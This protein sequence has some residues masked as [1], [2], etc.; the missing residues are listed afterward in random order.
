MFE[1]LKKAFSSVT[2]NISQ[3]EITSRDL[4]NSLSQIELD[5]L[6]CDIAQ[7]ALDDIFQK[8]KQELLGYKLEKSQNLEDLIRSRLQGNISQMFVTCK[9]IDLIQEIRNKSESKSGPF[10]IVFVGI[11]GSGKTTTVAKIGNRLRRNG[12]SVVM[13]AADTHRSGAIE[14]LCAHGERL[15]LKVIAQR[16]G[17]DPSAVGRDAVEFAKKHFIDVVLIDTAGRMQT[18]KNLMDEINKVVRVVKPDIKLFVGDSLAGNDTINQA[19]EFYQYTNFDAAI[20]TKADADS[21]GGSAISIVS[22]TSKPI[23]YFGIGQGYDDLL[24]FHYNRF[25]KSIFEGYPLIAEQTSTDEEHPKEPLIGQIETEEETKTGQIFEDKLSSQKPYMIDE[26]DEL[27]S[28]LPA[29]ATLESQNSDS[30]YDQDSLVKPPASAESD[31]AESSFKYEVVPE[32]D[33]E[34][35][36]T[37]IGDEG[38]ATE[39]KKGI[40]GGLFS[41]KKKAKKDN[42]SEDSKRKENDPSTSTVSSDK[43]LNKN[44]EKELESKKQKDQEPIYLSDDDIEDLIK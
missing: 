32:S 11:N 23:L 7:E 13:A 19:R 10:V 34:S 22:I 42:G 18:S 29:D 37:K 30:P 35:L 31:E 43:D 33:S 12:L 27:V 14:Q 40:F 28:S 24:P 8:L 15:S 39:K 38:T 41:R 9:S 26:A 5:L 36:P 2:S 44:G 1:K 17:A 20:L 3:K 21:K 16:Y 6:E 25:L 4:E